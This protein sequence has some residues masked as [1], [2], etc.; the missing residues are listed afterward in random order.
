MKIGITFG[1][2]YLLHQ[3]HLDV[4]MRAKKEN[5][6]AFVFVCGYDGEERGESCDLPLLKRYRIIHNYLEDES[7]KVLMLNDTEIGIDE[8]MSPVNWYN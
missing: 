7:C 6:I 3:G 5:D 8:S 1:G 2:Y 4:I